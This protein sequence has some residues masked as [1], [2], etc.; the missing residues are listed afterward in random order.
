MPGLS[1]N[2]A[3]DVAKIPGENKLLATGEPT[4]AQF[5][6]DF[7]TLETIERKD[8]KES[9]HLEDEI[10]LGTT[11]CRELPDGSMVNIRTKVSEY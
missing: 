2:A 1:D 8:Y 7:D 6:L 9:H 5:V 11:H 3:G 4:G 10:Q